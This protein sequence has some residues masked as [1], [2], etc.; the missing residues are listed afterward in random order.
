M[1]KPVM[2]PLV[3]ERIWALPIGAAAVKFLSYLV[4]KS[5]PGSGV[6]PPQ[7]TMAVEYKVTPANISR[8]LEPLFKLN[9]VLRTPNERSKRAN[10]Y[11]LHP[12]A[13]RYPSAQAMD[14]AFAKALVDMREGRLAPL[15]LPVYQTVPPTEGAPV[16]RVA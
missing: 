15:N 6:L 13:A 3:T 5:E 12:L 9:I 10:S 14:D 2:S 16:L 11:S 7:K 1:A 8:L 4:F